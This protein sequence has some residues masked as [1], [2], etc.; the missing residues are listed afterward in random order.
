MLIDPG[1][2]VPPMLDGKLDVVGVSTV[3]FSM[4]PMFARDPFD[5]FIPVA[6]SDSCGENVGSFS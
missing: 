4:M 2:V 1:P 5:P 3:P 6:D